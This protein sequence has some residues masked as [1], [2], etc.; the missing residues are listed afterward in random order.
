MTTEYLHKVT[1]AV[2]ELLMPMANQLALLFGES[3]ADINTFKTADWQDE[4][5]NKYSVCSAQCK[6]IVI[7]ALSQ[8]LILTKDGVDYDLAQQAYDLLVVADSETK[9]SPENITLAVGDD[10]LGA[11]DSMGLTIYDAGLI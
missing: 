11:L 1:I 2:P 8:G 5:G 3:D 4:Q 7:T 10:A 9:A 6:E